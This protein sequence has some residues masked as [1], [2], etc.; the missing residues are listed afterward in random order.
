MVIATEELG[1]EE[2]EEL[3]VENEASMT[4]DVMDDVETLEDDGWAACGI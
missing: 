3:V 4:D 2:G 1:M